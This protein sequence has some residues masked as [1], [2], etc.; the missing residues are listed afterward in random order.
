MNLSIE[1]QNYFINIIRTIVNQEIDKRIEPMAFNYYGIVAV[2][3]G[4]GT[5]DITVPA[6][7][8]TYPSIIN[9]SG[10]SLIVNDAVMISAKGGKIGNAYIAIKCGS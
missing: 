3:N 8:S 9:K 5:F 4:D 2:D 10:E 6:Q 7:N 1:E